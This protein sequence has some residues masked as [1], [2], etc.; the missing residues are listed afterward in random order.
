MAR[1]KIPLKIP[2]KEEL[3][4]V[5]QELKSLSK[6][7]KHYNTSN[8]TVRK[9]L[10]DYG[11]ERY[12]HKEAS[13][14]NSS[15]KVGR[16]DPT[17]IESHK[18]LS[19]RDWLYEQ[20]VT[21]RLSKEAIAEKAGCSITIVNRYIKELNIP[22]YR[23]NQSNP[24]VLE[25][26]NN[27]ELLEKLYQSYDM[28]K[29]ASHIGSSKATISK[30]FAKLGIDP[31]PA[32][33]WPR[34]IV[35]VSKGHQEII[36]H[37]KSFY[38]GSVL[39]NDRT[40]GIEFDILV[41]EYNLAIEYNGLFYH[42]ENAPGKSKNYHMNKTMMAEQHGIRLIHVFEDQWK[43][44]SDVI[45]SMISNA[46]GFSGHKIYARDTVVK[47]VSSK[48]AVFFFQKN[49]IQGY[50]KATYVYGLYQGIDLISGI[51]ISTPRFSR[52][53]S[54]EIIRF[55]SKLNT[56]CVGGFSKL[57]SY[58]RKKHSGPIVSYS[59]R[60]YSNGK[61]YSKCGF[62]LERTNPPSYWYID[63]NFQKRWPRTSFTKQRIVEKFGADESKSEGEI[64]EALGFKRIWN[65]G[66]QTWVLE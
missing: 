33:S 15:L 36:D 17:K 56:N 62:E 65:C 54:W 57:L 58:V 24:N 2:L 37:I 4:K 16:M 19:N 13:R 31:K 10:I 12:S 14:H 53:Y 38:T 21:N 7:A 60:T 52:D 40:Y 46:M 66:T 61:L 45:K 35:K 8:P 44:K 25:S 43:E 41:P 26:L 5:Y 3:E 63:P 20:R 11:I 22:S 29:I 30:A 64:M 34:T 9:W 28:G 48:E 6:T 39:I 59:D 27:K 1:P 49:H 50:G 51:S 18:L 42:H 47:E 23:Y 32:N 55:A